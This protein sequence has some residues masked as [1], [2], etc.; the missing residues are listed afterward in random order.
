M[1]TECGQTITIFTND[2][3]LYRVAVNV[4]WV[5][6]ER[7]TQ[8]IPRLGGMHTLMSFIGCVGNLMAESGLEDVMKSAFG[9]VAHMLGGKKFPQNFRALRLVTEEVLRSSVAQAESHEDLMDTLETKATKSMTTQLWVQNLV[10]P[11][12]IMMAFV[13]AEREGDRTLHLCHCKRR[14][15][16]AAQEGPMEWHMVGYVH[17]VH[18]HALLSW[19]TWNR[20][21][22][23]EAFYTEEVG[24]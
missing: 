20:W 17:G 1:T 2:Q 21:H 14:S 23:T 6:P 10:K 22:Y 8:F 19:H 24:L 12:F 11:V 15:R 3:Q 5:Y 9:G 18:V 4:K 13:R 7:F 16:D